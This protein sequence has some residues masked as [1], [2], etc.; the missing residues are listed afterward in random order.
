MAAVFES[1]GVS[2]V[3]NRCLNPHVTVMEVS[4]LTQ[5]R[6][7]LCAVNLFIYR[8]VAYMRRL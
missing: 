3:N 8:D 7:S 6:S 4:G 1:M 5:L 2:F